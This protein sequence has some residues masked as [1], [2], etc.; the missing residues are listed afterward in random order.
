MSKVQAA[1]IHTVAILV[2]IVTSFLV[3]TWLWSFRTVIE[4]SSNPT[5][6]IKVTRGEV[7]EYCRD[8]EYFEDIIVRLDKSLIFKIEE[9]K[10]TPYPYPT[11]YMHRDDG[12]KETICK[13]MLFPTELKQDGMYKMV[14]YVTYDTL[15]FWKTSVKLEDIYLNVKTK[16]N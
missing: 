1:T 9:K 2:G 5:E 12:F 15:P 4:V 7:F 11:S 13:Q 3:V 6:I 10:F 8:V 16:D 14:T